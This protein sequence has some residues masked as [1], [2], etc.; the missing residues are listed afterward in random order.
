MKKIL[1]V[2]AEFPPCLS[3]GVQRTYHF[4]ENLLRQGWE[5]YI[6]SA[7][8]RIYR[9]LDSNTK[10]SV[11]I[12]KNVTRSF[13]LDVS[14]HLA[15]KGKYFGVLEN[16]DRF[17]PWYYQGWRD[18]LNL[19]RD[20]QIDVIW[21]TYPISTAHRIAFKIAQKSG[22][23]WIADF[24]DPMHAHVDVS[25]EVTGKAKRI[26][27]ATVENADALVFATEKMKELYMSAYPHVSGEKFHVIENGYNEKIF[28]GITRTR[29]SSE[30]FHLLY[31][32][33]LYPQGR[34]PLPLFQALANLK[35]C[36][37]ISSKNFR[38]V[39]RGAGTGEQYSEII[40]E[41]SVE[42]LVCFLPSVNFVESIQEMKNADALLVLQGE[43]F[44]NQ[45][46]GKVYEYIAARVPM[47]ALVGKE[48][49][50]EQLLSS[51]PSAFLAGEGDVEMIRKQ[52]IGVLS[53]NYQE[54]G[55]ITAYSRQAKSM[56]LMKLVNRLTN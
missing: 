23:P 9:S 11:K 49:A 6:L 27:K 8:T 21:S 50:T 44:N 17:A 56:Q 31:S 7:D 30:V 52:L 4:A 5:P 14:R 20:N 37:E 39:F 41:L 10:V 29:E 12:S 13:A 48:G 24:R 40:K 53:Y 3:A 55:D 1:M 33:A 15:I 43:I 16:P 34:N 45:I 28:E 19:V 2:A 54:G 46:P 51:Y 18:G 36:E 38:L 47:L 35:K 26:D 25:A 42:E 32:G 22:I